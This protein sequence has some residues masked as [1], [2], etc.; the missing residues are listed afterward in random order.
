MRNFKDPI[1]SKVLDLTKRGWPNHMNN[2]ELKPF[3]A[4]RQ[5]LS[6]SENCVCFGNRIVNPHKLRAEV[7]RLLHEGHGANENVGKITCFLA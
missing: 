3:F 1:L 7:L 6:V 2:E 4:R 5:E